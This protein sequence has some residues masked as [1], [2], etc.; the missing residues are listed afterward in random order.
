M[1]EDANRERLSV[2]KKRRN[3]GGRRKRVRDLEYA[4]EASTE[5]RA[6]MEWPNLERGSVCLLH[7]ETTGDSAVHVCRC[8][9]LKYIIICDIILN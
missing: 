2:R 6:T 8:Q 3:T 1:R 7:N 5:S 9:R 4:C